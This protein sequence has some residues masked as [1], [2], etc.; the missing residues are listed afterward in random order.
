M[1]LFTNVASEACVLLFYSLAG[2]ITY[3]LNIK[4]N[5]YKD[6]FCLMYLKYVVRD[7]FNFDTH[8]MFL[9]IVFL[10]IDMGGEMI[11]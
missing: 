1:K 11:P 8:P 10:P 7:C 4:E 2:D 5:L 3:F 9:L 6:G